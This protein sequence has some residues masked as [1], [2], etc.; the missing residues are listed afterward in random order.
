MTG[1]VRPSEGRMLLGG[2]EVSGLSPEA[3]ARLAK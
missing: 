3:L 1:Y 2:E